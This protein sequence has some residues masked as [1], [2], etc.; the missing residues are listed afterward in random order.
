MI[1]CF[2]IAAISL[3]ACQTTGPENFTRPYDSQTATK[4]GT[5]LHQSSQELENG[6]YTVSKSVVNPAGH[7]EG[8]GHFSFI[9]F[10][11]TEI[12]QCSEFDSAFSPDGSYIIYFS[13][14]ND[15][16]ELY[17]T[18]S[19]KITVLSEEYIGYPKSADWNFKTATATLYLSQ[20]DN[21]DPKTLQI[22]LD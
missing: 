18:R 8:I 5:V 22:T 19:K 13:N 2:I 15:Q 7:W 9:Y 12:C 10:G 4:P 16:L 21:S 1:R 11:K 14:K 3:S 17:N 20:P 6:F